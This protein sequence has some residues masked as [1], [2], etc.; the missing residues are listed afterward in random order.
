M[1]S[2]IALLLTIIISTPLC[3]KV[4]TYSPITKKFPIEFELLFN[5]LQSEELNPDEKYQFERSIV[6]L[7]R[8]ARNM[9]EEELLFITKTE[10]YKTLLKPNDRT[11]LKREMFNPSTEY[12]D[13]MLLKNSRQT[14]PVELL[15]IERRLEL[16]L[17]LAMNVNSESNSQ[18]KAELK[19][20]AL[21][22]LRNLENAFKLIALQSKFAP[23][24]QEVT[25]SSLKF[26]KAEEVTPV[27]TMQQNKIKVEKTID[28][29][30]NPVLNSDS[31]KKVE[32]LPQP[33]NEN[34][35]LLDAE[36]DRMTAPSKTELPKPVDQTDWLP[37]F[38]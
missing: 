25:L 38:Q 26:F 1:K 36:L 32:A 22:L 28:D 21:N 3:A 5:F 16:A 27:T 18:L 14:P 34:E 35:W 11:A 13:L 4:F 7:D 9:N 6:E 29:I 20:K 12:K 37:D 10:I 15:K 30:L 33:V 2:F 31:D 8:L 19:T 17:K 23:L 24:A